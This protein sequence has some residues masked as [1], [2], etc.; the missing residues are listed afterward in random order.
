MRRAARLVPLAVALALA[1]A[2]GLA[3]RGGTLANGDEAVYAEMAREMREGG[4]WLTIRYDGHALH[5]RPPLYV[6]I[7]AATGASRLPTVL[8]TALTALAVAALARRLSA[9]DPVAAAVA[10]ILYGVLDLTWRYGRALESDPLFALLCVLAVERFLARKSIA[11]G[12]L[13][14]AACMVKQVVGF[15]PVLAP[16]ACLLATPISRPSRRDVVLTL[17]AF[18]AIWLPW[19]LAMTI[20]HGA[21]FWQGYLLHNVIERTATPLLGETS[22]LFYLRALNP[23]LLLLLPLALYRARTRSP[24]T[25]IAAL[26]PLCT[27]IAFTLARTRIE[28][29]LLA[30]TPF[31]CAIPI[32]HPVARC[33]LPVACFL[34]QLLSSGLGRPFL[35]PIDPSAAI[36]RLSRLAPHRGADRLLVIGMQPSAPRYYSAL[37]TTRLLADRAEFDRWAR[38]DV[39]AVPGGLALATEC[40]DP[41]FT[42]SALILVKRGDP[43]SERLASCLGELIDESPPY[44]LHR[45]GTAPAPSPRE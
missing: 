33:L 13:V 41:P 24:L 39:L 25:L 11:F 12:A 16:L 19:H 17:T 22:P 9:G 18:T 45:P 44:A 42:S 35:A 21:P 32:V 2:L 29:Y 26:I 7:L 27:L 15:L 8:F 6:W 28:Y 23:F 34:V 14:G 1:V 10:A 38:I 30:V 37:P 20:R 3:S 31:L 36:A 4:D 43:T 40:T 5:Q